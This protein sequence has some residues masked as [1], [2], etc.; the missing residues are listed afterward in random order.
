M[1]YL[2]A[3]IERMF[4]RNGEVVENPAQEQTKEVTHTAF[5]LAIKDIALA[6]VKFTNNPV[7]F[8]EPELIEAI[9]S[10]GMLMLDL[11]AE[12]G[13]L[14]FEDDEDDFSSS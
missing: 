2:V 11:Q 6:I 5:D 4:V 8:T 14:D 13:D 12:A 1:F 9:L 10:N 3:D 7:R